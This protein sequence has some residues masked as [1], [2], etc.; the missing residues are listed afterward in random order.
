MQKYEINEVLNKHGLRPEKRFGQ[1]FLID[2][3]ILNKMVD[4][5]E[6]GED[7][8]IIEVGPGLGVLTKQLAARAKRVISIEI[9]KK[10]AS[11]LKQELSG[12]SNISLI[13]ADAMKTDLRQ[14]IEVARAAEAINGVKIVANLPYNITTPFIC[15]CLE[16][17]LDV[18]RIVVMIQKEAA[19]RFL[20]KP[21]TK[22]YGV[23]TLTTECFASAQLVATVPPSCFY[24]APDVTSAITLFDV[25]PKPRIPAANRAFVFE[26]IRAA[27]S[28]RRKTL[29]NCLLRSQF[30]KQQII[31]ALESVGL[32][33]NVRGETLS[34]KQFVHL[35]NELLPYSN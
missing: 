20:A 5:A 32:D 31:A 6:I 26:L 18:E 15:S 29:V 27:F 10:L 25:L 16:Q 12:F 23:A 30:T 2:T 17:E 4:S 13:Q 1:N 34:L 24:P 35:T 19:E 8:L 21:S 11:V 3:N 33:A 7:D 28:T 22:A 14:I 9:D